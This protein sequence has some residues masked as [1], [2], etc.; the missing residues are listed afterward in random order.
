MPEAK[1]LIICKGCNS[2]VENG[3]HIVIDDYPYCEDCVTLCESC[4]SYHLFDNVTDVGDDGIEW[5]CNNCHRLHY[6]CCYACDSWINLRHTEYRADDNNYYCES[7]YSSSYFRCESCENI[8]HNDNYEGDGYCYDCYHSGNDSDS[9]SGY[10]SEYINDWDFRPR[11]IF[12]GRGLKMG[13]EIEIDDGDS[14]SDL[15]EELFES[16]SDRGSKFYIKTDGSLNH[17]LEIVSHP[18]ALEYHKG[19]KWREVFSKSLSYGFRSHNTKTCGIHVHIDRKFL[20]SYEQV[21][22]ALF[23][24]TNKTIIDKVAR[25]K[26]SSYSQFKTIEKGKLRQA[27]SNRDEGRY[28]AINWLNRN[29][30]EFRFF[31]GTLKH[32]TFIAS[33]EFIDSVVHFIKTVNT[34]QVY[35]PY[36]TG[37]MNG[38][39]FRLYCRYLMQNK[40]IY[41]ILIKYLKNKGVFI[42]V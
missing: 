42:C 5:V 35:D 14:H 39:A 3:S 37:C 7:C 30:I 34:R 17:G 41:S 19:F 2:D 16:W 21:K 13:V 31:K 28:Q 1:F 38:K 20:S 25:R 22:L 40:K 27:N 10:N 29:T 18:M 24:N 11:P 36:L 6:R 33:L 32:R 15:A 8:F 4:N 23:I 26:Q 9:D 12:Y